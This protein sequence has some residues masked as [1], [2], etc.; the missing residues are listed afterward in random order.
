MMKHLYVFY[1]F[2][3]LLVG[4]VSLGIA[5]F[6]YLKTRDKA[7]RHYLYF[8]VPFTLVVVFYTAIAY[9][10][11]NIPTIYPFVLAML[12][13]FA[14][15]SLLSLIFVVP[16]SVHYLSSTPYATRRNAIFAGIAVI[17][18]MGYH[19]VEFII[20]EETLRGCLKRI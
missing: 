2:T 8:Y 20:T 7:I 9:I 12:N 1:F 10:E 17:T 11:A 13:Y 19:I 6:V 16:V 3:T 14:T 4:I 18:Y 15:T 5:A